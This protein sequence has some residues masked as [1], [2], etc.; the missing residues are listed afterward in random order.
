MSGWIIAASMFGGQI[1]WEW[2]WEFGPNERVLINARPDLLEFK[3]GMCRRELGLSDTWLVLKRMLESF[4]IQS[5]GYFQPH[6][7]GFD[8][9]KHLV[10]PQPRCK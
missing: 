7:R 3:N 4:G 8:W 10:S 1:D 9:K 2:C 5:N 6:T